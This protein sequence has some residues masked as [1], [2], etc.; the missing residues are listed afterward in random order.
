[1]FA[2]QMGKNETSAQL[3]AFLLSQN[4]ERGGTIV[5][6]APTFK[7][8]TITSMLRLKE[9]LSASPETATRW[10]PQYGYM[11]RLEKAS[12]ASFLADRFGER[13][14]KLVFTAPAKSALGFAMLTMINTGR[15]SLYRAD[16]STEWEECWKEIKACRYQLR[17]GEQIG[18]S[19]PES[20]GHDDF[21]R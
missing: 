1:M 12:I 17:H 8:Q 7:P 6:A 3:E 2:R 13:I 10:Q 18:W 11:L 20:E 16:G 15:L 5:K 19:V 14:E 21:A 4:A 9:V